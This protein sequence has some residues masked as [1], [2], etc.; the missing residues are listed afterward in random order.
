[1]CGAIS[2]ERKVFIPSQGV[3]EPV[4]Q[5]LVVVV[6]FACLHKFLFSFSEIH[7]CERKLTL[8][9]NEEVGKNCPTTCVYYHHFAP[10]ASRPR[11]VSLKVNAVKVRGKWSLFVL[12]ESS[13]QNNGSLFAFLVEF[14]AMFT[15]GVRARLS[16]GTNVN[17]PFFQGPTH[18]RIRARCL[19]PSTRS[20]LCTRALKGVFIS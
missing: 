13:C 12:T 14:E 8:T 4:G 20:R 2:L 18:L 5:Y 16:L 17:T 7:Y 9:H 3:Y 1:M 10:H 15:L 6:M 11:L 19:C